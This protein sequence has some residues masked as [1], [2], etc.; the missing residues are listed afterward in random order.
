M[1]ASPAGELLLLADDILRDSPLDNDLL[2][3]DLLGSDLLGN[4]L[5]G[6]EVLI[7]ESDSLLPVVD[8]AKDLPLT[9]EP[10]GALLDEDP[11]PDEAL[12]LGDEPTGDLLD[13][14]LPLAN[15]L[16]DN[17][18]L[19]TAPANSLPKKISS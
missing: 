11:L 7:L 3:S 10:A 8:L 2:G 12:L 9:T 16:T 18:L 14:D 1:K 4:D 6:E 17:L 19:M 15:D 5:P 13:K